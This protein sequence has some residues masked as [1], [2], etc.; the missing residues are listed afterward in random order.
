MAYPVSV[1]ATRRLHDLL[2]RDSAL[3]PPVG[4][5]KLKGLV[6][7]I[8]RES[9]NSFEFSGRQSFIPL[10]PVGRGD[11]LLPFLAVSA[12]TELKQFQLFLLIVMEDNDNNNL[13]SIGFRFESPEGGGDSGRHSY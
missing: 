1:G 8:G 12:D 2:Q 7:R 4:K 3:P 6:E 9:V 10:E 5:Q 11:A 13:R